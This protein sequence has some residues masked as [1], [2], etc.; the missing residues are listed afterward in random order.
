MNKI[1]DKEIVDVSEFSEDGQ[2]NILE[3][4]TFTSD[5][6]DVR[7]G[8]FKMCRKLSV[9]KFEEGIE[10]IGEA[11][12]F[13]C[14]SIKEV[15]FPVSLK[16][17]GSQAFRKCT[18]LE[19]VHISDELLL[20]IPE[21]VFAACPCESGLKA[22]KAAVIAEREKEDECKRVLRYKEF[23]N[24]LFNAVMVGRNLDYPDSY[25][26]SCE[27]FSVAG[28]I[29]SDDM[30]TLRRLYQVEDNHVASV[31]DGC[32]DIQFAN[33]NNRHAG[34][35]PLT[36][37]N[38]NKEVLASVAMAIKGIGAINEATLNEIYELWN[39]F[40]ET[41]GH[42]NLR[43]VFARVIAALRPDL[44]SPV[45]HPEAMNELYNW[46]RANDFICEDIELRRPRDSWLGEW[47]VQNNR[48][49]RFL[50]IC[51][52]RD[53]Y[54]IG[55]FVWYFV[56]AFR[57]RDQTRQIVINRQNQIRNLIAAKGFSVPTR[58]NETENE[59]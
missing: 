48:I 23:F 9:L 3:S 18:E 32:M 43:L 41:V 30:E 52:D 27:E 58:W 39:R 53:K 51:L 4:V 2:E 40:R 56:E 12:F 45:V 55:S 8:S 37:E 24:A 6:R 19:K 20:A 11:A 22:R 50:T 36:W 57:E 13:G 17:I 26:K 28:C 54:A 15:S 44:V 31:A 10:K 33:Y 21:D 38:I 5:V 16:E 1:I 49:K 42:L 29:K 35:S 59:A 46:F 25:K 14:E 47:L 34:L 7:R